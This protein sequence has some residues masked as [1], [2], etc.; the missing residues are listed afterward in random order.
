MERRLRVYVLS[1]VLPRFSAEFREATNEFG[2]AGRVSSDGGE[3]LKLGT[4]RHVRRENRRVKC[5][6]NTSTARERPAD[7]RLF[8][9]LICRRPAH[10][11]DIAISARHKILIAVFLRICISIRGHMHD[12]VGDGKVCRQKYKRICAC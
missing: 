3:N 6:I 7:N 1:R 8:L 12:A 4:H 10:N 9:V 2:Q 11:I 5:D